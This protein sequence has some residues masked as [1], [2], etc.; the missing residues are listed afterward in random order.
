MCSVRFQDIEHLSVQE[1]LDLIEKIW[2]SLGDTP[3]AVPLTDAQRQEID[4]RLEAHARSPH[5]VESWEQV[6]SFVRKR[7]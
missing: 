3:D 2:D 6:K 1:R 7:K 4:R 5:E